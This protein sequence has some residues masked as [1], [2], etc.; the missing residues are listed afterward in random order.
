MQMKW[1]VLTAVAVLA[2]IYSLNDATSTVRRR[3]SL[4]KP[5]V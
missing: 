3:C 4:E 5:W 1:R 2:S